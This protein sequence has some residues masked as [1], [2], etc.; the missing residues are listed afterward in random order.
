MRIRLSRRRRPAH[1]HQLEVADA[2]PSGDGRTTVLLR[3]ACGEGPG[4]LAAIEL[5]GSWTAEQLR[6][7]GHSLPGMQS[8]TVQERAVLRLLRQGLSNH[9]I[10]EQMFLSESTIKNYVSA[11]LAKLGLR[12]RSQVAA[13]AAGDG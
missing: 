7:P 4:H 3:C 11:V 10:A 5:S 1:D 9:E 6:L 2:R 12:R 8:L 13:I